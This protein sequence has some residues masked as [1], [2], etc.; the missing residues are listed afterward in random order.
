MVFRVDRQRSGWQ[1]GGMLN[2]PSLLRSLLVGLGVFA[3]AP[4]AQEL[5]PAGKPNFPE[6]LPGRGLA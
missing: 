5:K 3:T 4:S 2:S 6:T 1:R